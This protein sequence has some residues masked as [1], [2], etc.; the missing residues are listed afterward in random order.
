MNG[1]KPLTLEFKTFTTSTGLD[2]NNGAY[3][4]HPSPEAVKT[5]LAKIVLGEKYS[6]TEQVNSIQKLITYSLITNLIF[7]S[8]RTQDKPESPPVQDTDES[9]LDSSP[10]LKKF[11]NILPLTERQLV[12]YLKKVAIEGY[13]EKNI[14]HRE[15]TDKFIDAAMNSIDKNIIARGDLLN[16]LNEVTKALKA[17]Q[18]AVKED[19]ILNKKEEHAA[20]EEEPT[21][22]VPITT[23][24]GK[25]IIL[26]DQLE[27]Q[28]KLVPASKDVRPDP[29]APII[30]PC[31]I[32]GK[33]FQ[34]TNEQIQAHLDKEEKTKKAT[35]EAKLFEMTKTEDAEHQVLKREHSQKAKRAM[36]PEIEKN[37]AI[38][39]P[40]KDGDIFTRLAV[41]SSSMQYLSNASMVADSR[42]LPSFGL[43]LRK[44]DAENLRPKRKLQSKESEARE[45]WEYKFRLK[46]FCF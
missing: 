37:E 15:Q 11:D 26:D 18:D 7:S 36:K 31:E 3:V 4:A 38:Q 19:P 40:S 46:Y 32:N 41:D 43:K 6:S 12:K 42:E 44:V 34:L 13:Y 45:H 33:I 16:D 8:L 23:I 22:V 35:E 30:M 1:K 27:D 10:D 28:R 17:I 9:T 24:E 20:M 29:D 5:E 25:A 2:Y 21:N 39:W 14:D